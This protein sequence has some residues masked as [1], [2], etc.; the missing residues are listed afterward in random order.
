MFHGE[1]N[2][3]KHKSKKDV[4]SEEKLSSSPSSMTQAIIFPCIGPPGSG[5]GLLGSRPGAIKTEYLIALE[6][7]RFLFL[8]KRIMRVTL[9]IT[10]VKMKAIKD[11]ICVFYKIKTKFTIGES[12]VQ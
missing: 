1:K 9:L 4:L 10:F 2:S 12:G 6:H 3:G 5:P 7:V 8:S 11:V